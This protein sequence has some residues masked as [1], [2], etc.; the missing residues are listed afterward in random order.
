MDRRGKLQNYC[1]ACSHKNFYFHLHEINVL[2]LC[3][4]RRQKKLNVSD[5][6]I[7]L[8]TWNLDFLYWMVDSISQHIRIGCEVIDTRSF[9]PLIFI[10]TEKHDCEWFVKFK[11]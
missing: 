1:A 2:L 5:Y 11:V 4:S 9:E 8:I 3:E 10:L 7:Y 6:I